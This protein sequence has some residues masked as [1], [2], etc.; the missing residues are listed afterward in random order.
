MTV[1]QRA[2]QD[3]EAEMNL[4]QWHKLANESALQAALFRT[5]QM[6]RS[7][8]VKR[9]MTSRTVHREKNDRLQRVIEEEQAK[10]LH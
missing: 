8:V 5:K 4:L 7:D 9:P 3:L 2:I 10:P 6:K 1:H